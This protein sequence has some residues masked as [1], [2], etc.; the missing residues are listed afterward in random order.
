MMEVL[1][2]PILVILTRDVFLHKS[3]AE[4]LTL[5]RMIHVISTLDVFTQTSP[6]VINVVM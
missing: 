4:I 3:I 2:Q 5:A 1:A 6:V